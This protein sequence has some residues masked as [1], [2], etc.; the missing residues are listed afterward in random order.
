MSFNIG[1]SGIRASSTDLSV[2]GNN[3]ANA[4]TTGF[5][6][7]RAEFEDVYTTTLLGTGSAAVGSGVKVA[8]VRQEF[9][10]GNISS[11]DSVLDMAIDGNGF[12]VLNDSGT[13]TYTR[14]GVF[15]LDKDGYVVANNGSILQGYMANDTGTISG[16]L[17][18]LSINITSQSPRLTSLVE[19]QF[20][21]DANEE[22]LQET[23]SSVTT[24]GLS[25]GVVNSGILESTTTT[26]SAAGQPTTA[27]SPASLAFTTDLATV[28]AAGYGSITMDL[29]T[30]DGAVSITLAGVAAGST[31][32]DILDDVQTAL[33]DAFGSQEFTA[34]QGTGGEL[35]IERAGYSA[36]DGSAF[37]VANT[38]AFDAVFGAS[39]AVTA[40]TAGSL[41]FVGTN[42]LTA[43][44]TSVAGTSTTTRTTSTPP[45]NIAASSSGA[46]A[47]LT[48]DN[49]YGALDL[50]TANGNALVFT[51]ATGAGST[52]T[53]NL[54]EAAWTSAAPGSFTAVTTAEIIAEI[55][56][57]V[58]AYAG[59]GNEDV[60]ASNNAGRIE[61]TVQAPATEGDYVQI[62]DNTV[63]SNNLD[64]TDL[65]FLA[66]NRYD[67]G[68]AP[69]QANNEFQL[70]VTSTTG[71]GGGPYTIT[72]PP[73]TY[74][75]LDDL[76]EEIQ[77]QIDI[78]IGASGIAGKV[79]VEAVNGQLVF[80]NT[81]TGSGEGIA[82]TATAAEPQAL[83]ALGFDDMYEV[84]GDDEIDRSNSFTINLT[85]PA[86]DEE[87]RSGSVIISMT[88]EYSSVQEVVADINSQLNAQ[89]SD[90]YIGVQAVAVEVT[91]ET[92][93]PQYTIAFEAT[94]EGE[95]SVISLSNFTASGD[96]ITIEDLYALLQFDPSDDT[97]LETGIAGVT[98]G[99]PETTV[100][101][102]DPDGEE[103]LIT[104]P[105]GSEANEIVALLND[106]A[107]ITASAVTTL[108]ITA[109]GYNSPGD[110]MSITVNGQELTATSLEDLV[111]EINSYASTT[112]PGFS[113]ELD[114]EGD[115][116]ITNE[117]GS[118]ITVE[119]NSSEVTDSLV[120]IGGEDTSP[121]VLGGS[122]TAATAA[123]VG[124]SVDIVLNEDYTLTDPDPAI[125]GIFGTLEDDEYSTYVLN[126]FDPDD[127][128]TYNH[129]T[130]TTIYDSLGISHVMT[131][132]FVKEPLDADNPDSENVWV[133]YVQVDGE[134]VGD[135][136]P[137]LDFPQNLEPTMARYV[138]YFNQDGTLD[139]DAT[140]DMYITNWDPLDDNGDPTGAMSSVNVLEGGLPLTD[141][142]SSSNF[143]ITLTGSTQYGDDF[144]VEEIVQDGYSTGILTGLEIDEDGTISAQFTNGE[145]QTIGQVA[146]ATF[147]NEEGL[148]PVGDTAW[149]ESYDSGPAT[150]G[151]PGTGKYGSIVSSALE[152]SNVD[153]S[154]EL[155]GL[156]VAQRNYQAS[157]KTIETLDQVTQTILNI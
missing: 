88:K 119:M 106:Y 99:Y 104:I 130:S 31:V 49:I 63:S 36:T 70:E 83:A 90:S 78:Y 149:A 103:T 30:G 39:G 97:L 66:A 65:G 9:S 75:S 38:A 123:T 37:T 24:T 98:N 73:G 137:T 76:A 77:S 105:E 7:S 91:P 13:V 10:Q 94:E 120:L 74:S 11:T 53:I 62:A 140:G 102:T 46:Y 57:Q 2:T 157:A 33:D 18:D 6:E 44:F 145:T 141:P 154:E 61:F 40:G 93:P 15:S 112:L 115:L 45:L 139:E 86:P 4:S 29:N 116:V 108:T 21:L 107:G 43:D 1:L 155:V 16:V 110:D 50:S 131:Q 125:S 124:G 144:T 42:P 58:T 41:L 121:A 12:Y 129:A 150:I 114:D 143:Q 96:D 20:N 79:T 17:T 85:V 28:A 87:G 48:A 47:E 35:V 117:I 52:Y 25:V 55:N 22:V 133:M 56:A 69:V 152:D 80:T 148:T 126:A 60:V 19:A 113:A 118:D 3:I 132:Y 153:L 127:A 34:T 82:L 147:T 128:D 89:D 84:E 27:G 59:A 151:N 135:P 122:T 156:I 51:L 92:S 101:L 14:S 109:A 81:T 95:A 111:T 72:I 136:D 26:L 134:D 64:L 8:N 32:D 68:E 138:L 23:G 100:T 71:N 146:L 54:S 142:P 5:K 67:A